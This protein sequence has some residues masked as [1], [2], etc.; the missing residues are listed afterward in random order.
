MK[1]V[2]A[3]TVTMLLVQAF[4]APQ[5]K[6]IKN[7]DLSFEELNYIARVRNGEAPKVPKTLTPCARAILGCCVG[8]VMNTSCSEAHK[9][10]GLFFDDNPCEDKFIIDALKAARIFYDQFNK[11]T[12]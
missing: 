5:S 7:P 2:T 12:T 11:V 1:I 8:K 10:G 6:P 4:G 9:C 3:I